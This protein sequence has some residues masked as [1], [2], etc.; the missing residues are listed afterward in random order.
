MNIGFLGMGVMGLPMVKNLIQKSEYDVYGY[1][2]VPD[3]VAEFT[4]AGGH[5]ADTMEAVYKNCD[6]IMQML[7]THAVIIRSIEN[8]IQYGKKGNI[9]IDLSSTAPHIIQELYAKTRAAGMYLLDSPVSGGNTKAAAGT[10]AIMTGGDKAIFDQMRPLLECMGYPVYT[11]GPGSGDVTKLINNTIAGAYLAAIAEGY[12]FA[13]K[14]GIDLQTT[15]E[16]T[17]T[18]FAGGPVY[19]DKVP[20]IIERDYVPGARIAVHRKDLINAKQYAHHLGIDLPVTDVTLRIM[21]WMKDNGYID[22]DQ[23]GIIKYFEE[24]MDVTVGKTD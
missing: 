19:E 14:A 10:L 23:A 6:I 16:A 12:A 13:A 11:G 20:K 8:A 4:K 18:G 7:P 9:I 2:I 5:P 22:I 15:F 3:Q 1:D 17:R 24:K 21:D